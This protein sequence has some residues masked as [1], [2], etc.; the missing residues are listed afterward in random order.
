MTASISKKELTR[1]IQVVSSLGQEAASSAAST[2]P[3]GRASV[4]STTPFIAIPITMM[5]SS[6]YIPT[7]KAV[8]D[9]DELGLG[10][11]FRNIYA[12]ESSSPGNSRGN[13][14]ALSPS[15]PSSYVVEKIARVLSALEPKNISK[16]IAS[17]TANLTG[18]EAVLT[19]KVLSHIGIE[20]DERV[21]DVLNCLRGRI[22][23]SQ[24]D[25]AIGELTI[26]EA[27][28]VPQLPKLAAPFERVGSNYTITITESKISGAGKGLVVKEAVPANTVVFVI[29]K[30]I[31]HVVRILSRSYTSIPLHTP[32]CSCIREYFQICQVTF[33]TLSHSCKYV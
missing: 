30:P 1:I 14:S 5:P 21:M 25:L 31:I 33:D 15:S 24:D 26:N 19:I 7:D 12:S 29:G 13:E 22:N 32:T 23:V 17:V 9:Q 2:S 11:K 27:P 18:E 10:N 6:E 4:D 3:G 20:N 8:Q 16:D 28:A